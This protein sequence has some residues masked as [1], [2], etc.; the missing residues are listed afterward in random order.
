VRYTE[1]GR[2][3]EEW[4]VQLEEAAGR[5]PRP[6]TMGVG[7]YVMKALIE[8]LRE[9]R[10]Q[11]AD[12][13]AAKGIAADAADRFRDVLSD[14]LGFAEENPG[15]D[16]LVERLREHF[17]RTGPEPTRWRDFLVGAR[18]QVDQINAARTGESLRES[19]GEPGAERDEG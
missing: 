15:D 1:G 3:T 2:V 12:E 7:S 6:W 18:A 17:G 13:R 16:V 9:L 19:A 5:W 11:V 8:E 4:L 14:A 10:A